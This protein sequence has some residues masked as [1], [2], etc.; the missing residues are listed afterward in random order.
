MAKLQ[1]L[2]RRLDRRADESHRNRS[3]CGRA[4]PETRSDFRQTPCKGYRSPMMTLRRRVQIG[5]HRTAARLRVKSTGAKAPLR[6][7]PR[8]A[9]NRP[10]SSF[11]GWNDEFIELYNISLTTAGERRVPDSLLEQ[12]RS[13]RGARHYP[14]G[15]DDRCGLSLPDCEHGGERLERPAF[16]TKQSRPGRD[17][18]YRPAS[19]P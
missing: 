17:G 7:R 1:M 10:L 11:P 2:R 16:A 9:N 18:R 12:H 15:H 5:A 14:A 13:D 19:S 6:L 4:P 8:R 3:T